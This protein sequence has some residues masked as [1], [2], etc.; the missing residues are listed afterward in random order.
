LVA[1]AL[2]SALTLWKIFGAPKP[3][4]PP[5]WAIGWPLYFV[6]VAFVHNRRYGMLYLL[7]IILHIVATMAFPGLAIPKLF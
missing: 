7:G 5:A 3:K 2:P 6:G 4:T 1:L